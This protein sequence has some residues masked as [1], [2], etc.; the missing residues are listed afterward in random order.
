MQIAHSERN[1]LA[2]VEN[3]LQL[4]IDSRLVDVQVAIKAGAL[5]PLCDNCKLGL[6]NYAIEV[7]NV[8][9]S[10][11][12]KDCDLVFERGEQLGSRIADV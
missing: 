4:K 8:A 12:A 5:A 7:E 6:A 10:R 11:L 2:N 9:V 3:I 1:L